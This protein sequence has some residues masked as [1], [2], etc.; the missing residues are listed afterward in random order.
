MFVITRRHSAVRD[1]YLRCFSGHITS[2][3]ETNSTME[4][5]NLSE[6]FCVF[7]CSYSK[8]IEFI[9]RFSLKP[10]CESFIYICEF[11]ANLKAL[12]KFYYRVFQSELDFTIT[13]SFFPPSK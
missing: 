11:P 5:D 3:F 8:I 12:L 2:Y 10:V 6:I 4:T 9:L 1:T 7:G 13:R